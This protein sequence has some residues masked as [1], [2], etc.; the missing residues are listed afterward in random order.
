MNRNSTNRYITRTPLQYIEQHQPLIYIYIYIY[1][2][3]EVKIERLWNSLAGIL[4]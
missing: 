3:V 4:N 1:I 2:L